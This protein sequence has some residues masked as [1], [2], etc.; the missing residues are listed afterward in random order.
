[1]P[2][3]QEQ[4]LQRG[5]T[6]TTDNQTRVNNLYKESSTGKKN[7]CKK[8]LGDKTERDVLRKNSKLIEGKYLVALAQIICT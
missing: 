2:K 1:M 3:L 8:G 5:T 6:N 4:E 7:Y